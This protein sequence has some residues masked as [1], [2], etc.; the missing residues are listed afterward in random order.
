[1][2]WEST[3]IPMVFRPLST[4]LGDDGRDGGKK[5]GW[6]KREINELSRQKNVGGR[7]RVQ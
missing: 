3:A 5:N 7:E 1:M 6:G 2:A 4:Y